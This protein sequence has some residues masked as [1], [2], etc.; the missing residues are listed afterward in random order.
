MVCMQTGSV[1]EGGAVHVC[2]TVALPAIMLR[3]P[4]AAGGGDEGVGVFV[5]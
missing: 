5:H 2:G 1:P 3:G 4:G